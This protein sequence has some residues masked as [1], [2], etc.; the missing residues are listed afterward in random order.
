M[1]SDNVYYIQDMVKKH[2][3]LFKDC[4]PLKNLLYNHYRK[5]HYGS[6]IRHSGPF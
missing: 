4:Y 3:N 1:K 6:I 2:H 5:V